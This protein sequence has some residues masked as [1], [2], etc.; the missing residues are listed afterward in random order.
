[1]YVREAELGEF[2]DLWAAQITA[3][4]K[5]DQ[6]TL[7][8]AERAERIGKLRSDAEPLI[9]VGDSARLD[10]SAIARRK[11]HFAAK[12]RP[13]E[14]VD[15]GITGDRQEPG[16]WAGTLR[17]EARKGLQGA[18]EGLLRQVF[19]VGAGGQPV[20]E[21]AV[22]VRDVVFKDLCERG[23]SHGSV[24][25]AP[26]PDDAVLAPFNPL[27][28][29]LDPRAAE[30]WVPI[31][32]RA[33]VDDLHSSDFAPNLLI[34]EGVQIGKGVRIGGNAVIHAGTL[35]GDDVMIGDC[36][37]VGKPPTLGARSSASREP[38]PPAR[39]GDRAAVLA[40]AV[41]FAGARIAPGAIVGDQAQ[42]RENAT[43][44][45]DSLVGR[46]SAVDNGV[47]VG[48]RVSIQTNCYITGGTVVADDVFIG[49]GVTMT[50]DNTMS[51]HPKGV[52]HEAPHLDRACRVGGGS[53]L[54]PGVRIGEESFVAAGAVVTRDVPERSVVLGVPA[55][56]IRRVT[57]EDLLE[58]WR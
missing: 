54:C 42:V 47:V 12:S 30:Y 20:A 53:V 26:A 5:G 14:V 13:P 52:P 1:L 31:S 17:I 23:L 19:G 57:E 48:D 3:V 7:P 39:I 45:E 51:R 56:E 28:T 22:H 4:S 41:V 58:N 33:M 11:S 35:I 18:L 21:E 40:G 15:E 29:Q 32:W 55:R 49:P 46:G 25:G 16:A 37:V 34:G 6:L 8:L 9:E 44:G 27:G 50:N 2:G 24:T 43:I 38:P 10:K 36:A